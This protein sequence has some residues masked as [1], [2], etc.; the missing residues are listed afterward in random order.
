MNNVT[1][2]QGKGPFEIIIKT[3]LYVS[4]NI[5]QQFNRDM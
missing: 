4:Q 1:L 3:K 2:K 5:W